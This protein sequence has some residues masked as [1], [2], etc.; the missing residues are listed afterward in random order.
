MSGFQG[1]GLSLSD[2][3]R[4]L[5]TCGVNSAVPRAPHA[6]HFVQLSQSGAAVSWGAAHM[7]SAGGQYR[8]CWW[9]GYGTVNGTVA[10]GEADT[11]STDFIVDIGKLDVIGPTPLEQDRTCVSGQTCILTSVAGYELAN[12]DR[13]L[14]LDTCGTPSVPYGIFVDPTSNQTLTYMTGPYF[15]IVWQ[16]PI[17]AAGGYYSLCWCSGAVACSTTDDF[18]VS[19]GTL[20]LAGPSPLPQHHT[21]TSGR[22][23]LPPDLTV[24]PHD[25]DVGEVAVLSSCSLQSWAPTGFPNRGLLLTNTSDRVTAGGGLYTL[26][27]NPTREATN[28]SGAS[29]GDF[30][31]KWI[32]QPWLPRSFML[33]VFLF[34]PRFVRHCKRKVLVLYV[35]IPLAD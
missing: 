22:V 28:T 27:W 34:R 11:P 10:I 17:T 32:P 5:D 7:S 16:T 21:C 2:Q 25:L 18:R 12:E 31:T 33:C 30:L 13:W 4:I 26:C 9:S 19:F 29:V 3:I 1:N 15:N 14:V 35:M 20:T 6:G 24:V 23:C 8:L